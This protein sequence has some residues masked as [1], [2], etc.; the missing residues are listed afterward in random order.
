M[1]KSDRFEKIYSQGTLMT[2]TEIWIDR[3]TGVNYLYHINGYSG[4]LTPL[5]DRDG[6]PIVSPVYNGRVEG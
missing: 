5:L 1:K 6:K 2:S 4:G 3:E